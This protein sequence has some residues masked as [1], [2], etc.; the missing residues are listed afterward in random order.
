MILPGHR[1]FEIARAR[2]TTSPDAADRAF[3]GWM[4]PGQ[5]HS[6]RLSRR[7]TLPATVASSRCTVNLRSS[8]GSF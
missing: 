4:P 8:P 1:G 7:T 5:E 2:L 6:I 3:P